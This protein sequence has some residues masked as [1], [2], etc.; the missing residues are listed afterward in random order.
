MNAFK[1]EEQML[2]T[3]S[4]DWTLAEDPA[5]LQVQ[6]CISRKVEEMNTRMFDQAEVMAVER[7]L[8]GDP[9]WPFFRPGGA[10]VNSQGRQP[11]G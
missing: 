4:N 1:I 8:G 11:L 9:E 3:R 10:V 7:A 6:S 5:F 2:G